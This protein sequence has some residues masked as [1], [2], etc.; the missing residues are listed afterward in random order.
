MKI[1][2]NKK[3]HD[4]VNDFVKEITNKFMALELETDLNNLKKGRASIFNGS[5]LIVVGKGLSSHGKIVWHF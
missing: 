4:R 2:P 5:T 3:L 1:Q